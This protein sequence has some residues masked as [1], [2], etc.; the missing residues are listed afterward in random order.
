MLLV[1]DVERATNILYEEE[2]TGLLNAEDDATDLLRKEKGDRY[3]DDDA[4]GLLNDEEEATGLLREDRSVDFFDDDATGLLKDESSAPLFDD[5]ATGL[6]LDATAWEAEQSQPLQS[7][8]FP[9]L[10]RVLTG[11]AIS[12]NKPIFRIGKERSYVDYFVA[13][14]VAVSRSHADIITRGERCFVKD[15]NSKNRTFINGREI[16]V[17]QETEIFDGDTLRLANEDFTFYM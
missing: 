16:P 1:E 3:F 6:L 14:N 4:T 12:V 17:M 2:A 15:L 10:I 13:N 11:E 8:Q 7:V 5:D 9:K